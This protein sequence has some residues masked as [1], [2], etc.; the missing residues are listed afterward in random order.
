MSILT[1]TSQLLAEADALLND[2]SYRVQTL[3]NA[4]S[5]HDY[6][7]AQGLLE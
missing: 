3:G 2:A 6:N 1:S 4:L 7:M 5:P